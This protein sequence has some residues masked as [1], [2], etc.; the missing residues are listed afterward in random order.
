LLHYPI[1][2]ARLAGGAG[3]ERSPDELHLARVETP[4]G[5]NAAL[6][7]EAGTRLTLPMADF[8]GATLHARLVASDGASM[9]QPA[10]G[11]AAPPLKVTL[12]FPGPAGTVAL[13]ADRT[14]R[15]VELV[16]PAGHPEQPGS[17]TFEATGP[18]GSL[19]RLE[20]PRLAFGDVPSLAERPNVLFVILD[21]L[22]ADRL[23]AHGNPDGLSPA[24]DRI[25]SE[26]LVFEECWS[27]SSWTMPAIS[28][29]LTSAH[30]ELH[31]GIHENSR[32]NPALDT[33]ASSLAAAGYDTEAICEGGLFR[34]IYGHDAGFRAF[35]EHRE[36]IAHGAELAREFFQRKATEPGAEP[37]FLVL[38]SYE[39]HEPYEPDPALLATIRAGLPERLAKRIT[40]PTDFAEL[41]HNGEWTAEVSAEVS[42]AMEALYDAEVQVADAVLGELFDELRAAGTLDDTLVVITADHGEEFGEHGMIGHGDSLYP[43]L[44]HVPLMLRFPDG[45]RAGE[46]EPGA[47]SQLHLAPTVLD[48]VGLGTELEG[49]SFAGESLLRGLPEVPIY[50]WR[51]REGERSL[52][53]LRVGDEVVLEGT[54]D[55]ARAE[56]GAPEFYDLA[57]DP[58]ALKNLRAEDPARVE[59]LRQLL[60]AVRELYSKDAFEGG[61]VR[62]DAATQE[63]L[64]ALGYL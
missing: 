53:A 7:L 22:R 19:V 37:W 13:E 56:S 2:A 5:S 3:H 48:A 47:T 59:S 38:H 10:T 21:T 55:F 14:P 49:L 25:A 50:A 29:M 40:R 39:V 24:L 8:P 46:T 58:G 1:Q 60:S 54:Y 33:L 27:T 64:E 9:D 52:Y 18:A 51:Y 63:R 6:V 11:T 15:A 23:G 12:S 4:T 41:Y 20:E 62:L 30:Q 61:S 26:S 31:G 32:I 28:G 45:W 42:A 16:L 34:A 44:L 35:F 17:F 57:A 36:G 43:E